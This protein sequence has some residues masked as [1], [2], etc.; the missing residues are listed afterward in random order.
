MIQVKQ[1]MSYGIQCCSCSVVTIYGTYNVIA[2]FMLCSCR[3]ERCKMLLPALNA[4][5]FR[6]VL[7]EV[8]GQC[9]VCLSIV[10]P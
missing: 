8:C 1:T 7:S 9:S 6:S 2:L 3:N 4:L 5:Y 10:V